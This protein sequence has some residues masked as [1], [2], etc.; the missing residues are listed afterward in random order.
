[1]V[2]RIKC[3][4]IDNFQI[5]NRTVET[6]VA[7]PFSNLPDL[8]SLPGAASLQPLQC[9]AFIKNIPRLSSNSDVNS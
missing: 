9:H 3:D 8:L 2:T 1:M 4:L 6:G 7:C 5:V